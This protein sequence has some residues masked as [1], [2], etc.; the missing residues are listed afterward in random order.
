MTHSFGTF[1]KLQIIF[2]YSASCPREILALIE[3]MISCT[4]KLFEKRLSSSCHS[5]A[6]LHSVQNSCSGT[7]VAKNLSDKNRSAVALDSIHSQPIVYAN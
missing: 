1:N 4:T 3:R 5:D 7:L 6:T 2:F